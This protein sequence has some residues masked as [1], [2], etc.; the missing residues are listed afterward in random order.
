MPK[1][2]KKYSALRLHCPAEG[3]G[4]WFRNQSQLRKHVKYYHPPDNEESKNL[5][6]NSLS[7]SSK[8]SPSITGNGCGSPAGK[9]FSN[10]GDHI[11][12][13]VNMNDDN[14]VF[15]KDGDRQPSPIVDQFGDGNV[16]S[17]ETHTDSKSGA[18]QQ[19]VFCDERV[20]HPIVMP[21]RV[22]REVDIEP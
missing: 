16:E 5:S 13:N 10:G 15:S 17:Q 14:V 7:S 1:S 9:N 11:I 2:L 18:M 21:G 3:C 20:Y 4:Q 6:D 8:A 19:R 12:D 22:V